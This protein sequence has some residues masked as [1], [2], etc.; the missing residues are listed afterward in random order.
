MVQFQFML[1][2]KKVNKNE[3]SSFELHAKFSLEG[4]KV[5]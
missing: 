2:F 1:F 4:M 5:Q 3:N